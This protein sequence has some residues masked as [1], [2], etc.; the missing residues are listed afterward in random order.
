MKSH[1][2]F[3]AA[4]AE[5]TN[6]SQL[7]YGPRSFKQYLKDNNQPDRRTWKKL[8]IDSPRR[9]P[10][11]LKGAHTM[12]F[13]LGARGDDN[14]THFALARCQTDWRDYF[15][16]DSDIAEQA[17][18]ELFIPSASMRRLF[19]FQ[20]LPKMTESSL[21][22]LALASGMMEHALGLEHQDG[23]SIPATA[24]ARFTFAV[25]P[26]ALL[27]ACW[28]HTRGQVE[29][30]ALFLA[31]RQGVEN[32]FIVEAKS[33]TSDGLAKHKLVYPYAALRT[34]I[35]SYMEIVPVY[36]RSYSEEDGRHF[37]IT[38]CEMTQSNGIPNVSGLTAST[39]RHLV[40]RF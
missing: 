32:L 38:E 13:R 34:E 16:L 6:Q 11:E 26:H 3:G 29:I 39:V 21:V 19:A 18:P 7:T 33:D 8:S 12:V 15:L 14:N 31:R 28:D 9:L 4:L 30:D 40:L 23:V 25:R 35:P 1:G 5:M 2:V 10:P 27:D 36:L 22:N 17:T 24:Q 37:V 20:L